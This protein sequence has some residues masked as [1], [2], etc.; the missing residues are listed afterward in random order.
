MTTGPRH[1]DED[2]LGDLAETNERGL[3]PFTSEPGSP[4]RREL[5]ARYED[6]TGI[7]FE[8]ERFHR[9]LAAFALATVWA[10]LHRYSV[11]A[12]EPSALEPRIEY[13]SAIAT[14]IVEGEFDL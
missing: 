3:A 4:S 7:T 13:V 1:D 2:V 6:R 12:G 5:V 11:E 10:D 9:A 14:S 8:H